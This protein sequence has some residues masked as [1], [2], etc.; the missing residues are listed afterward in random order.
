M[1]ENTCLAYAVEERKIQIEIANETLV[2]ICLEYFSSA[3]LMSSLEDFLKLI[4]KYCTIAK[5]ILC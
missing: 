3:F 5:G 1:D 2:L 4:T